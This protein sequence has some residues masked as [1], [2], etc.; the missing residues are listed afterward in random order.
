MARVTIPSFNALIFPFGQP[1][2]IP[3]HPLNAGGHRSNAAHSGGLVLPQLG[4]AL[5]GRACGRFDTR[6]LPDGLGER[7]DAGVLRVESVYG[8]LGLLRLERLP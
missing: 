4:K 6:D 5:L 8:E 1:P 7:H 3:L 2:A